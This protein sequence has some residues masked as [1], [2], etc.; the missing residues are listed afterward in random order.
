VEPIAQFADGRP[1]IL[2]VGR[3]DKRKGFKHL[4]TAYE[5][6]KRACPQVRLLAVGAFT[7]DDASE[8]VEFAEEH[9]LPDVHFIGPVPDDVLCRYY[10]TCAIV[11]VPSTGFESFGYVLIEAMAAGKPVVASDIPGYSFVMQDGV[12]GLLTPPED[13]D[14]IAE[15]LIALV[16]DADMRRRLGEAGRVRAAEF[17]WDRVARR[18]LDYYGTLAEARLRREAA[19]SVTT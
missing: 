16:R 18:V 7:P 15:A 14:A 5:R 17:S 6:V 13:D 1:S 9:R 10:H 8:Y 2:F 11:C 19:W 3:L 4:L 12:Q